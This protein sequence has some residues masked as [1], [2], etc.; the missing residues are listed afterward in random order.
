MLPIRAL[1]LLLQALASQ[2]SS[3]IYILGKNTA[4]HRSGFLVH[5]Y[6]TALK[7]I[8]NHDTAIGD[9]GLFEKLSV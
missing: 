2:G 3:K 5:I 6:F 1:I 4:T 8:T 9:S 7:L